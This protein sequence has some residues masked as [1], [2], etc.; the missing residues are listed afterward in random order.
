MRE[1]LPLRVLVC[2]GVCWCVL[3]GVLGP[4]VPAGAGPGSV[5][6]VPTPAGARA[7]IT[8]RRR[9]EPPLEKNARLLVRLTTGS[10]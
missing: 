3:W 8:V 7:R 6:E 9:L 2:A 1:P 4:Q 10:G 5:L